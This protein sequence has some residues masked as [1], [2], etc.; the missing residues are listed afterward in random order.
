MRYFMKENPASPLIVGGAAVPF[1]IHGE[2]GFLAV[3][4]SDPLFKTL[5][6]AATAHRGGVVE[7]PQA[8]Y[9]QKKNQPPLPKSQPQSPWLQ[10]LRAMPRGPSRAPQVTA[11]PPAAAAAKSVEDAVL[12]RLADFGIKIPGVNQPSNPEI[13][14]AQAAK[15]AQAEAKPAADFV[16][17]PDGLPE[18][19]PSTSK[20]I[21]PGTKAV[22]V[23]EVLK[24]AKERANVE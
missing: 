11:S 8:A 4:E 20:E 5:L 23:A 3:L 17:P 19:A 6:S 10:P 21:K 24:K 9:D 16:V 7:I 12:K 13:L 14:A 1:D 18:P 22:A 15:S 2:H